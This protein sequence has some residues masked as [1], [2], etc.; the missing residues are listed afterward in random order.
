MLD[1]LLYCN[2]IGYF[3]AFQRCLVLQKSFLALAKMQDA[4]CVNGCI[5]QA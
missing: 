4:V 2:T 3:E 5:F 1:F